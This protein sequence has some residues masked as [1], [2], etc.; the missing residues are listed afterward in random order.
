MTTAFHAAPPDAP[1]CVEAVLG[2]LPDSALDELR[3]TDSSY[4]FLTR[5]SAF[6]LKKPVRTAVLDCST[7]ERRREM[8]LGETRLNRRLAPS[9]YRGVLGVVYGSA[10][11]R[12]EPADY[13][14]AIEHVVWMHRFRDEDTLAERLGPDAVER[15]GARLA[16]F[17]A[18][19]GIATDGDPCAAARA[20]AEATF[21][22]AGRLCPAAMRA[23]LDDARRF[24]ES[25]LRMRAAT[26]RERRAVD[27]HGDLRAEHVLL[28]GGGE[29]EVVGCVEFDP[30]LRRIDPGADLASLLLDLERLGAPE[31]ARA[32]VHAYRAHGGDPG[33][34]ASIAFHAAQR[35]WV[36][37]KD[38]LVSGD[39]ATAWELVGL[40]ATV[41]PAIDV[42]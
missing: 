16:R 10:G 17:H 27:G 36:L 19:E 31:L 14:G 11:F 8:C 24:T 39:V 21:A 5:D 3:E 9:I 42:P 33:D 22:T 41:R 26:M 29:V 35:A 28:R 37:A 18:E 2:A 1:P 25:F 4:V 30:A 20:A 13:P 40:A 23:D 38:A 12:F 6:R 34:D 32:L 15:V 7:R